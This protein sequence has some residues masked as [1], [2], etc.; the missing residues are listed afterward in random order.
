MATRRTKR[1]VSMLVR[2]PGRKPLKLAPGDR[3]R[4]G[5]HS[6][7]EIS[8]NDGQ[9]SR[10]HAALVW[11]PDEDRPYVRDNESAN[12]VEL[13][14]VVIDERAHLSGG[15]RVVIGSTTLSLELREDTSGDFLVADED[16][17]LT[18]F[19]DKGQELD[20]ALTTGEIERLLLTLEEN[21][22]TGTLTVTPWGKEEPDPFSL[23]FSQ[24]KVMTATGP[25]V[26]AEGAI[27]DLLLVEK[28]K[29]HFSRSVEPTEDALD[30][31]IKAFLGGAGVSTKLKID[32]DG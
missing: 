10:F 8:L 32:R 31:S 27:D 18:L 23:T 2:I 16:D 29:Y 9:V 3:L 22:R 28:G 30:L 13:D 11:D 1:K 15:N 7:N 4:I 14:G 26:V 5:R 24:G 19:S 17:G 25:G 12:G 6:S 21:E 20:G